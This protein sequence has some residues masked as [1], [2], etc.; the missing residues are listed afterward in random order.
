MGYLSR[1]ATG[2][3]SKFCQL[4][5]NCYVNEKW[6][7]FPKGLRQFRNRFAV[8]TMSD[9]WEETSWTI[10]IDNTVPESNLIN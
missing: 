1:A 5:N 10:A 6:W 9:K 7:N 3:S 8:S 4:K 2:N